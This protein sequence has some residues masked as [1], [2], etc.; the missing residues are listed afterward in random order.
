M[1]Y[2]PKRKTA[3]LHG[4]LDSLE[5]ALRPVALADMVKHSIAVGQV[6]LSGRMEFANGFIADP[7]GRMAFSGDFE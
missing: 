7:L 4:A 6:H 2:S 5:R 1:D 3:L